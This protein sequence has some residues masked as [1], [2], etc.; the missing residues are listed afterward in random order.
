MVEIDIVGI[1]R[2]DH[3]V[4]WGVN[5]FSLGR[6]RQGQHTHSGGSGR[7]RVHIELLLQ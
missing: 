2:R 1:V 7:K 6:L 3:A 5:D 4:G